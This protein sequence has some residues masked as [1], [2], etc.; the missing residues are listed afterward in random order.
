MRYNFSRKYFDYQNIKKSLLVNG[1]FFMNNL[2]FLLKLS[3]QHKIKLIIAALLSIISTTLSAIP[4]IL[5]YKII[6]ELFNDK[7][8]YRNIQSLVF[9]AIFFIILGVAARILSGIFS[10]ISA[11]NILYKIRI[12]LIEHMSGLNMGFFKKSMTGKLKKIINE[13]VE[14]LE[15]F[16]AHQIPDLSSAF[17]TPL[18]FFG[19]ML[20]FNWKLS[21]VLFIPVILGILAQSGMFKNYMGKVDHFYKLVAK[22]N[23]TIM[24]YI[25]AMNVMKAFNLTAKSFKD[26]RDNTQEYADYWVELTELAVPYYSA[27][28]CLVDT[29]MLFIIPIGGI[30]LLNSR[31]TIPV[32][33]LFL[34]MS[35][36]FLNSLKSLFELSQ[37]LSFLL[38]GMEKIIE[39]FDE[40]EQTSGNIKFPQNF[41]QGLKYENITFAYNKAKVINDFTLNIKA[42]TTTALVGPSGS[43]KTTIGLL[44]GRFWDTDEGKIT[45]DGINIK[46]IS[47]ESL[48]DN[49]SFVFQDTFMLHDTIY[50]NILMGKNYTLDEVENAAKK[51]QIHDFI[52]SLPD[53]YETK[54]GEG[55]IKL[56]GGEKQ[57]I[58]IARAILK[59]TPIVILDEV[60]SYSDIENEA[61]IQSA[62]KTLLKGKTALI[63]AHRLYT[64]KNA[65]N[66]VFMN[67]GKIMEQGTHDELLKNRADYWHLWSLYNEEKQ[68]N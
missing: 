31:I 45:I 51:A 10:H 46:D 15:N 56:S 7:I 53:K 43:G 2:K 49:V 42:G 18:I 28:L 1:D 29:G 40:K 25:N 61:K 5:V 34:L 33:I 58:S 24:E 35:T 55:G 3:G 27:F 13:D 22:L 60:T 20:Y 23:S 12:D 52:M 38:K 9:K 17:V 44:A 41:S 11:F 47:Y 64:I 50:E 48:M 36:I 39:I 66:I 8:D 65:D 4:Y 26:Y 63:I 54:I 59:N 21:L 62:L 57:R 68:E 67:K 16:I 37:N 14:K 6:L 19:I 30:M 32:Y